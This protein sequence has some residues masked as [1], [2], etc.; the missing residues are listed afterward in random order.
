MIRAALKHVTQPPQPFALTDGRPSRCPVMRLVRAFTLVELLVVMA[1][2]GVMVSVLLP[3]LAKARKAANSTRDLAAGQ[4]LATA[5]AVYAQENRDSVLPAYLP[6]TW[7]QPSPPPG[8]PSFE[9]LDDQGSPV[10]GTPAQRYPWRLWP[11]LNYD[12]RGLYKDPEILSRFKQRSDFQYVASL[13]PSFGLNG[14]FMGGDS[15]I[16]RRGFNATFTKQFGQ[17]YITRID[18]PMRPSDLL[19]FATSH[20]IDPD[21]GQLVKGFFRIDPPMRATGSRWWTDPAESSVNPAATGYV[22]FRHSGKAATVMF[23]GHATLSGFAQ[24]DDMRRWCDKA[25]RPDWVLGAP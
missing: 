12:I 10:Y 19:V 23:D 1:V 20:G 25:T 24:L 16:D 7:T 3:A 22:D 6:A 17:F 9:V 18:Q 15:T 21:G 11:S 8:D 5:Y 4:S 2:V 13:S 14:M